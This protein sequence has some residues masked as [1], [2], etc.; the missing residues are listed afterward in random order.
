MFPHIVIRLRNLVL[1]FRTREPRIRH[2]LLIQPPRNPLIIQQIRNTRDI[3]RDQIRVV[4]I[5]AK[6][7]STNR[8][9]I[10]RLTR[11]R[12]SKVVLQ[13]NPL[14]RD[15]LQVRVAGGLVV[16]GVFE[17]DSHEAVEGFAADGAGGRARVAQRSIREGRGSRGEGQ[18]G[19]EEGLLH[20]SEL[21]VA[22]VV[23]TVAA[24]QYIKR[25]LETA[26]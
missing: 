14:A 19:G 3:R 21:R 22:A 24:K 23:K 20:G 15:P 17:P 12:N 18:E 4:V 16:V 11:V 25:A 1:I 7:L 2:V 5:D 6:V 10:V 13:R 8:R 26:Q 9:N